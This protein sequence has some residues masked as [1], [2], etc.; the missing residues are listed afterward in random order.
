MCEK[1]SLS[2]DEIAF[3]GDDVFDLA[4]VESV[5]FGCSVSDGIPAVRAAAAYVT[6]V[7]GGH[8]AVR[9]VA[10]LILASRKGE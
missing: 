1:Y 4:V 7:A 2:L 9:E 5:G 3:V 10:E 8:G 6:T